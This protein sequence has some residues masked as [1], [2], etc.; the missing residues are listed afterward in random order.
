MCWTH[1][2]ARWKTKNSGIATSCNGFRGSSC[3]AFATN[4][5][6]LLS[7]ANDKQGTIEIENIGKQK[8]PEPPFL[9]SW[10]AQD[11]KSKRP[12]IRYRR[13]WLFISGCFPIQQSKIP[14]GERDLVDDD[15]WPRPCYHHSGQT[16]GYHGE[17]S[18]ASTLGDRRRPSTLSL[19]QKNGSWR[20]VSEECLDG[21]RT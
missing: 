1:T 11:W 17:R 15:L 9:I 6:S 8:I 20:E 19:H 12:L 2:S 18:W 3:N 10:D 21:W 14:A 4:P 13:H 7:P 5:A 16:T